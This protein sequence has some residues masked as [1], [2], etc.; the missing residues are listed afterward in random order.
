M[1]EKIRGL[2]TRVLDMDE[3]ELRSALIAIVNGSPHDEAIDAAFNLFRR[4]AAK[5]RFPRI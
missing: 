5:L 1:D 2:L 4:E 3:T